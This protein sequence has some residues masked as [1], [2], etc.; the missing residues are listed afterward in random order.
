MRTIEHLPSAEGFSDTLTGDEA[1]DCLVGMQNTSEAVYAN[2]VNPRLCF[3]QF[4]ALL[5]PDGKVPPEKKGLLDAFADKMYGVLR[6]ELPPNVDDY[7]KSVI[8][9]W[10]SQSQKALIKKAANAKATATFGAGGA[11]ATRGAQAI[12]RAATQSR[13]QARATAAPKR[14]AKDE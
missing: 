9:D 12:Q 10:E 4:R 14:A 13:S 7:F 6:E 1:A 5:A 8:E 3:L 2:L 11:G